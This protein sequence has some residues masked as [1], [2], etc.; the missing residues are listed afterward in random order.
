VAERSRPQDFAIYRIRR[1]DRML[2]VVVYGSFASRDA[3][4]RSAR[5]PEATAG[6]VKPWLRRFEYVQEAVRSTPQG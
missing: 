5:S 3:A 2:H 1:G 4:E 6:G